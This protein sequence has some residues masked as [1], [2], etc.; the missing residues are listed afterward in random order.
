M[1]PLRPQPE[2]AILLDHV[3]L[4]ATHGLPDDERE[5]T[6]EGVPKKDREGAIMTMRC[7]S[8]FGTV[9]PARICPECGHVMKTDADGNMRFGGRVV[10][11]VAGEIVEVDVEALRRARKMEVNAARS[12]DALVEVAKARGYKAG[13]ILNTLKTRGGAVPTFHEVEKAMRA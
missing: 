10:K 12:L 3:N 8:C 2:P 5:W 11:E 6:L 9:R 13:W 7:P 4:L 1:R